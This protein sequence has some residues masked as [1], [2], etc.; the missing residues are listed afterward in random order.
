MMTLNRATS[1]YHR[2]NFRAEQLPNRP[3]HAAVAGAVRAI[4]GAAV[5]H[6]FTRRWGSDG[7]D[8]GGC[9]ACQAENVRLLDDDAA[10]G[11]GSGLTGS[12]T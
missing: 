12:G 11:W 9:Q 4:C 6:V 2:H 7:P 10:K 8:T 5:T 1:G 3:T